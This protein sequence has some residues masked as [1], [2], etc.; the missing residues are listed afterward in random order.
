M[1][2]QFST[3]IPV[4]QFGT[5]VFLNIEGVDGSDEAYKNIPG[6]GEFTFTSDMSIEEFEDWLQ[7]NFTRKLPTGKSHSFDMNVTC[8]KGEET[9]NYFENIMTTVASGKEAMTK[10]KWTLLSGAIY[11]AYVVVNV[12]SIGGGNK[13]VLAMSITLDVDGEPEVTPAVEG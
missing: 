8:Y 1:K 4:G 10:F 13:D 11:E 12:S 9:Y 5:G 2:R 3:A 6:V 7:S